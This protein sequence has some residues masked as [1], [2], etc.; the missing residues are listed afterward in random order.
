MKIE[1]HV[2]IAPFT[3][4][5]IGG[6]A[7][8]FIEAHTEKDIEDAIA[9][10]RESGLPLHP[11]GGGSNVLVPDAGVEGVVLKI[12]L[13][14]IAFEEDG[15]DTLL[16][17]GAG[18]RWEDVV[19][20]AVARGLFGVENLAGIPGTVGGAAVQNI[21]AYGAELADAFAHA[22]VI[23]RA[24]GIARRIDHAEAAFAYRTSL[25]KM[26]RELIIT[27]VALRL[28]PRATPNVAYP[29]LVRAQAAGTPLA[30]P[31]EIARAIRAIR[32]AKFPQDADEGTAGS[33]FKNPVISRERAEEFAK[34]FP[35]APQF[36]QKDG[37]VK[38]PLAWLLDHALELKGFSKGAARLYEKQPLVIVARAGARAEEVDALA[39]EVAARVFAATGIAIER[40]VEIFGER[41]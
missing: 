22:D 23:D 15:A 17:A 5:H 10:A 31:S 39:Q 11:L 2:S 4:F 37:S 3:T 24:T 38:I 12:A 18:A 33:F 21:G 35:E 7:R 36:V 16:I 26:H 27:R 32:A 1:E 28:T 40:E 29:D 20:C 8:F 25:F 30:T 19:D 41:K 9:F 34:Q 13:G 14:D 6:E